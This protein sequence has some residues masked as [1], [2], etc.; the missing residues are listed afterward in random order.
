MP[1]GN[2]HANRVLEAD[3]PTGSSLL[4]G[5]NSQLKSEAI[6]DMNDNTKILELSDED[7]LIFET[8]DE[9]LEAAAATTPVAAAAMSFPNAPTVSILVICCG[10]ELSITGNS[11]LGR[12][13]L[14]RHTIRAHLS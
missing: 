3:Q 12:P 7:I 1:L 4:M 9:T 8:S 2:M 6:N 5:E 13:P 10:N 11:W 14:V